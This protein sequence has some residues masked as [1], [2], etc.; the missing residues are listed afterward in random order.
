[1]IDVGILS[2][3]DDLAIIEQVNFLTS[4][5]D[6]GCR[7]KPGVPVNFTSVYR[8]SICVSAN[9][10]AIPSLIDRIL[11]TKYSTEDVQSFLFTPDEQISTC[12]VV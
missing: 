2:M 9:F 4:S 10:D 5:N 1:M 8:A 6:A 11:L 3:G 12:C 7:T